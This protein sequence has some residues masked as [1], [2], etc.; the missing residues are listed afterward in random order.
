[1]HLRVLKTVYQVIEQQSYF[2]ISELNFFS[3]AVWF[4]CICPP[5]ALLSIHS[6]PPVCLLLNLKTCGSV[7]ETARFREVISSS[8]QTAAL[9][10]MFSP[11]ITCTLPPQLQSWSAARCRQ[12][13]GGEMKFQC[14]TVSAYIHVIFVPVEVPGLVYVYVLYIMYRCLCACI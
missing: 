1:M 12:A 3:S 14:C 11:H 8:K 5:S 2:S 9:Y 4:S 10:N 6:P 13:N 7:R